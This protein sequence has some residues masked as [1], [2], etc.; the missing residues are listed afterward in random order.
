MWN[1]REVHRPDDLKVAL[2]LLRRPDVRTVP[3]AGGTELVGRRDRTIEALVDLRNLGLDTIEAEDNVVRI[4]AMTT[5]QGIATSP[6]LQGLADGPLART[7]H[8]SAAS[9]IRNMATLG[10]TLIAAADTADLP[11]ALLAL[12]ARVTLWAP[13]E[14]YLSLADFYAS[15]GRVE[16]GLL[17]EIVVPMP[18]KGTGVAF[19]KVGRTPADQAIISVAALVTVEG[20]LCRK[21]R[22]AVGGIGPRP[23]RM[24]E[25]EKLLE[26]QALTEARLEEVAQAVKAHL[27]PRSDFLA[28]AEYRREVAGVMARRALREA[29]ERAR[30]AAS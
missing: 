24:V 3:L 21:A 27:E 7:A 6:L 12:D 13:D 22:L 2:E 29:G 26:G 8:S 25:V 10:G 15:G 19:H 4:G 14:Q 30:A 17:T 23:A 28:S 1:L 5:L 16:G 11:P 9:L 18:P 20:G